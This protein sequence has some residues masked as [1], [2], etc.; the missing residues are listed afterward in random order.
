MHRTAFAVMVFTL[1]ACATATTPEERAEAEKVALFEDDPRRGAEVDKVCFSRTIDGFTNT[2]NRAVVISEGTKEYLV[3]TRSRCTDLDDAMSRRYDE[4]SPVGGSPPCTLATC[5]A[6]LGADAGE[7]DRGDFADVDDFNI[8]CGASNS[9]Q[10]VFG[11]PSTLFN[12]Y[13]FEVCV[14]YDGNY[15]GTLNEAGEIDAKVITVTVTP[16]IQASVV[17]ISAYR[18]NY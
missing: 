9:V 8:F 18:G 5:S 10:D 12:G 17:S 2:T 14:A 4:E 3:T 13:S 1:A 7:V 11:D 6:T 16:P 15:N